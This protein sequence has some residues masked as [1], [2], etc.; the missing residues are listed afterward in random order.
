MSSAGLTGPVQSDASVSGGVLVLLFA[1]EPVDHMH[2]GV[3]TDG[4]LSVAE[5]WGETAGDT[6]STARSLWGVVVGG[7]LA[8]CAGVSLSRT[9][10]RF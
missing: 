9:G 2:S 1:S 6:G 7:C 10:V 5:G 8:A 4:S 3:G